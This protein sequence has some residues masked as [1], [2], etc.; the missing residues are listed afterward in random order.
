MNLTRRVFIRGAAAAAALLA[1]PRALLAWP[2]KAFEAKSQD[3][4]LNA[5]FGTTE[6]T[7]S[8]AVVLSAPDIAENGAVVPVSVSS[9]LE[10]VESISIIVEQ[11]PSPLAASFDLGPNAVADVSTR[12]KM[13]KTSNVMAVVKADG[14]LHTASKEV[15]V[16]IGGCGG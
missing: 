2:E 13:G 6:T 4:T 12:L 5:L 9:T 10:N 15:K 11:N 7:E 1:L 3:D 14:K 16:T 8:S